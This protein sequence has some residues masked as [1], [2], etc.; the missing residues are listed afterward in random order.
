MCS[1]FHD[2]EI[3]KS[4]EEAKI[5]EQTSYLNEA[6]IVVLPAVDAMATVALWLCSEDQKLVS[7]L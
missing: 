1:W 5:V 3:K 6:Y 7:R 4:E 2:V